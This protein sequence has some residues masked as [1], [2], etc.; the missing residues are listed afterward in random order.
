MF[1]QGHIPWHKGKHLSEEHRK[2][3]QQALKGKPKSAEHIAK[4]I[5]NKGRTGQHLSIE[6]RRKLGEAHRKY[7][8]M[9]RECH[10]CAR[11]IVRPPNDSIVQFKGRKYCSRNCVMQIQSEKNKGKVMIP[12]MPH[13]KNPAWQGGKNGY[14]KKQAKIRDRFTCRWCGLQD[15]EVIEVDHILPKSIFP[16]LAY[17]LDNLITLCAN[18][19][20]RK[21]N[22]D[23]KKYRSKNKK[24][25]L[26]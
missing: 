10:K 9:K 13:E 7:D 17:S 3:I 16:N 22:M 11:I 15:K 2:K 14:S 1:K 23:I 18:D 25:K 19:H 12:P 5:G 26:T 24:W 6:H 8:V 20:R 4:L 21:T